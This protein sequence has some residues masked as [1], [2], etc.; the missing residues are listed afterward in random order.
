MRGRRALIV[1]IAVAVAVVAGVGTVLYIHGGHGSVKSS[2]CRALIAYALQISYDYR[3]VIE[4]IAEILRDHGCVVDIAIGRAVN[5]S[6]YAHLNRYSIAILFVHGGKA[7][8]RVDDRVYRING[9][10]TGLPWS[11]RYEELK[12]EWIATR[13]F[14]FNSTKAFLA[15][16]PHFFDVY[17]KG[18]FPPNSVVVVA[19]C[20]AL[21][22]P[23]IAEALFRHGLRV[24]IGWPGAVTP[25]YLFN[26][27]E[28]LVEYAVGEGLG[29]IK[30]V[31]KVN[32]VV[33]PDPVYHD[34][35]V[36]LVNAQSRS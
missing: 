13:A 6:L 15:V 7:V 29:W 34:H 31:E 24:F 36:C 18:R 28:K 2:G 32:R 8:F 14:P 23:Y 5:L 9:L 20:Y 35:I 26:A 17:M 19:G 22:T 4:R 33:G 25:H 10:F 27:T 1:A 30:A 3:P 21:Y 12:R 11:P 16:L